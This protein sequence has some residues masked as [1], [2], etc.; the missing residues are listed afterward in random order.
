MDGRSEQALVSACRDGD[1]AAYGALVDRHYRQVLAICL[2]VLGNAHDAEDATQEALVKGFE[3]IGKLRTSERFG[4][5]LARIAKNL[6]I[7]SLRRRSRVREVMAAQPAPSRADGDE[8]HD[9][10]EAVGR[11]PLE[12]RVPLVMYYFDGRSAKRI[13]ETLRISHRS[14][15][16]RLRD[17]RTELHKLLTEDGDVR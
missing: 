9:L 12:L 5:W 16:Q 7:D 10:A 3:R 1:K 6:S 15:C 13:A 17:A 2:G 11:L 4:P 14:A 8:N